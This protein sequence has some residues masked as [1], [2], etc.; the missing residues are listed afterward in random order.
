MIVILL[1]YLIQSIIG[2]MFWVKLLA[3]KPEKLSQKLT[4]ILFT[5]ILIPNILAVIA[6]MWAKISKIKQKS[7]QK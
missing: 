7:L 1:I 4:Y 6:V 5:L 3:S 2:Y